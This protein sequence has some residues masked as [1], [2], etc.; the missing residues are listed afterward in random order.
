MFGR[1]SNSR[2]KAALNEHRLAQAKLESLKALI[3]LM[4]Q[5]ECEGDLEEA[6]KIEKLIAQSVDSAKGQVEHVDHMLGGTVKFPTI[7]HPGE[8]RQETLT[9]FKGGDLEGYV[10]A[11]DKLKIR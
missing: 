6:G 3:E 2:L 4:E 8:P 9:T 7:P 10:S 11:L 1:V 5:Y